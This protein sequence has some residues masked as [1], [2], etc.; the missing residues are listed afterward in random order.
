MKSNIIVVN[1]HNIK[2]IGFNIPV[3]AQIYIGRGSVLGNPYTHLPLSKSKALFQVETREAAI[4]CYEKWIYQKMGEKDE[5]I[6]NKLEEIRQKSMVGKVYLVCFCAPKSCHG[7]VIK[8]IV[9][10]AVLIDRDFTK[11]IKLK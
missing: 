2:N 5:T 1:Q 7:D 6:L 9:D 3:D 10:E 4:E 8:R 11:V